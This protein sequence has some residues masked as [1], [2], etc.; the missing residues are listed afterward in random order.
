M[1]PLGAPIFMIL[2]FLV[3]LL[4]Y[5]H[6]FLLQL[7]YSIFLQRTVF[8]LPHP[9]PIYVYGSSHMSREVGPSRWERSNFRFDHRPMQF[10]LKNIHK[11]FNTGIVRW[12]L[13]HDGCGMIVWGCACN[14][15]GKS[16]TLPTRT[17]CDCFLFLV[18]FVKLLFEP[19]DEGTLLAIW[20]SLFGGDGMVGWKCK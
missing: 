13:L 7:I 19:P 3:N 4:E 9:V 20:S 12:F 14:L 2:Q 17:L 11:S 5:T 18:G 8:Q 10:I 6:P 1:T 15:Q 16:L